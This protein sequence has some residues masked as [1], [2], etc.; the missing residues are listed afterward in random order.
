MARKERLRRPLAAGCP[1]SIAE[2]YHSSLPNGIHCDAKTGLI[3]SPSH[4]TWMD[5]NYPAG[6]PRQGYPVEIQVLWIKAL[7]ILEELSGKSIYKKW[8]KQATD[9]FLR[10]F[11]RKDGRG[12]YDC[13]HGEQ[14]QG[15]DECVPDDTVRPNQLFAVTLLD[16]LPENVATA[17]VDACTPLLIPGGIRSLDDAD[18]AVEQPVWSGDGRLLN[19]PRH[20]YIGRYEGDEDTQ[21]KPAYHNGTAWGWMMPMYCEALVEVFGTCG[22]AWRLLETFVVPMRKGCL[23]HIPEIYDGDAPHTGRGCPAQA[24]SMAEACRVLLKID[25]ISSTIY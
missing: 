19:N 4:Y 1:C 8:A 9:S 11:V 21:R 13:L 6:T 16:V 12:L 24:W 2:H 15:A 23:G 3:F 5:T 10:L 18:V 22:V 20:P 14:G 17:V 25:D 7:S